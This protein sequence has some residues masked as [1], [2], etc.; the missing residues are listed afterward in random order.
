M[1]QQKIGEFLKCLRRESGLTQEQ[2]AERFSVSS[3]TV[4]RWETGSN[5]PDVGMLVEL[6][7]FYDVDIREIIDGERKSEI[8]NKE[9]KETILKVAEYASEGEKQNQSAVLY[10]ALGVSVTL[11]ICTLLFSSEATGLLNGIIPDHVCY[12][13]MAA[14]YG[15]AF[16]LL[17]FY[18]RV[19]P[20]REKPSWEPKQTVVAT[21]ISK[22]IRAGTNSTGRSTMGYSFVI[23][24]ET[25]D[26]HALELY[27][28]ELEYGGLKEGMKG[29]L[30]YQGRYFVS[31]DEHK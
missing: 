1:N 18:I 26:G 2:L 5:M 6:A 22:E 20:F 16:L 3:R 21:V 31:F 25:A 14:V 8:M 7:D 12:Y 10:T 9:T 17:L 15:L 23:N 19:R 4:S 30:T 11:C 29:V 24:F 13:I 28:Y 27:A